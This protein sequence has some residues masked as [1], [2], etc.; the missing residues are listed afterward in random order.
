[1]EIIDL[2][3]KHFK[4]LL[5]VF[6]LLMREHFQINRAYFF[7]KKNQIYEFVRMIQIPVLDLN[8]SNTINMIRFFRTNLIE[9]IFPWLLARLHQKWHFIPFLDEYLFGV[10]SPNLEVKFMI[11]W[12]ALEHL[13]NVFWKYKQK[14]K[15]L[16]KV[17]IE[18]LHKVIKEY[19]KSI[20]KADIIFPYTNPIDLSDKNFLKIDNRPPIKTKILAMCKNIH[21]KLDNEEKSCISQV[22]YIRNKLFHAEYYLTDILNDFGEEFNLLNFSVQD[23]FIIVDKFELVLEKIIL[24]LL[25]FVPQYFKF[26]QGY[27][28]LKEIK[29]PSYR[30]KIKEIKRKIDQR[31]SKKLNDDR[32][33]LLNNFIENKKEL[34]SEGKYINLLKYIENFKV[35]LQEIITNN[36]FQGKINTNVGFNEIEVKFLESLSGDYELK[37]PN[38]QGF[39]QGGIIIDGSIL[40][41]SRLF[42]N[43]EYSIEFE[44]HKTEEIE[45]T[46]V[47]S[48]GMDIKGKFL[49]PLVDIKKLYK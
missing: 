32:A 30:E 1:M 3:I 6:S 36:Y 15:L 2:T 39:F 26:E 10:K 31:F 22:N 33:Y 23:F 12:N 43:G 44:L 8:P 9:T 48:K 35:R 46:N 13:S 37:M 40:Q 28:Q 16:V 45:Q 17:K 20:I 34:L 49:T 42:N 19:L 25:K 11:Y 4:E 41:S 38:F 27:L 14:S 24:K 18:E 7:Q 29:L 47:D 5:S 21:L